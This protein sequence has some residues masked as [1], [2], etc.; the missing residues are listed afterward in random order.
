MVYDFLENLELLPQKKLVPMTHAGKLVPPDGVNRSTMERWWRIGINGVKL[1]T[2]L[3]GGK[4][5]IT[6]ASLIICLFH[7]IY[8]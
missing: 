5:F 4:R 8:G 2:Y 7:K 1:E 6:P 3:V